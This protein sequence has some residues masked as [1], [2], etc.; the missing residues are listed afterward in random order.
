MAAR[1]SPR[2]I[3]SAAMCMAL[4]DDEHAVS[5]AVL[6]PVRS[7]RKETRLAIEECEEK[8]PV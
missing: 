7:N 3:A 5:T 6:G 2:R 8:A 4:S 1:Q